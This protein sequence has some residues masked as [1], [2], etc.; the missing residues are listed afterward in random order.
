MEENKERK[1]ELMLATKNKEKGE[2]K[3]KK[4]GEERK[5]KS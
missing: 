4:S 2:T 1:K 5:K 3:R